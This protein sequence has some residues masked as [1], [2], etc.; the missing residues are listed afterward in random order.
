VGVDF[1]RPH[2]KL[3]VTNASQTQ[4]LDGDIPVIDTTKLPNAGI[5]GQ[6]ILVNLDKLMQVYAAGLFFSFYDKFDRAG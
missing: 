1:G 2:R 4:V 3:N 6:F 5:S